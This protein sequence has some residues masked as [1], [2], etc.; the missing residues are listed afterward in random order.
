MS[1]WEAQIVKLCQ[2]YAEVREYSQTVH[3]LFR[4]VAIFYT[5]RKQED[6]VMNDETFP[7]LDDIE[8]PPVKAAA[9]RS[10]KS[11][12][13]PIQKE[14]V[15]SLETNKNNAR[16]DII[17]DSLWGLVSTPS[18]VKG[19]DPAVHAELHAQVVKVVE[20]T[21]LRDQFLAADIINHV[22]EQQRY[23][24]CTGT[25]INSKRRAAFK[26]ILHEGIGL[27]EVDTETVADTYFGV[28]RLEEREVTDYSTQARIPKTRADVV[29]FMEKHGFVESDIEPVAM[30]TSVD[31]LADLDSLALKHEIQRE[32]IFRK[33]ERRRK[34][35]ASRHRADPRLDG[36]VHLAKDLPEK[37]SPSP[38]EPPP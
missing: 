9:A 3:D 34:K 36:K 37:P 23:R 26:M 19:E 30:E 21:N 10:K 2:C 7:I 18:L 17:S 8:L 28:E 12:P 22:W 35:S 13:D 16:V 1:Q 27:N 25:I 14:K 31:T 32:A 33:L 4:G 24:R 38:T 5:E 15:V 11:K 20:P 6:V 29:A